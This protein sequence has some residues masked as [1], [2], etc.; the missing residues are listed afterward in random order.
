MTDKCE[1]V[2]F[3][4]DRMWNAD[5]SFLHG[6]Q[7]R[8]KA[9]DGC[10]RATMKPV[11]KPKIHRVPKPPSTVPPGFKRRVA[12]P[13]T[14]PASKTPPASTQPLMV[15][16][17]IYQALAAQV[18]N[19]P[20]GGMGAPPT[21][22]PRCE[23]PPVPPPPLLPPLP[24]PLFPAAGFG[25]NVASVPMLQPQGFACPMSP[26][27][28]PLAMPSCLTSL[29]LA[30]LSA[31]AHGLAPCPVKTGGREGAHE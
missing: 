20:G 23:A 24:A 1:I 21:L 29:G 2:R 6:E 26:V 17:Q 10:R 3:D 31:H 15:S 25:C 22:A 19:T 12:G 16:P 8:A 9:G 28:P 27:V 14:P 18:G 5:D 7:P 4:D 13:S 11:P 30:P